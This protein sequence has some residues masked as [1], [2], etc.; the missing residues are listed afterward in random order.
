MFDVPPEERHKLEWRIDAAWETKPWNVGLIVGPSGAGKSTIARAAFGEPATCEWTDAS[1]IDD[2]DAA[3]S[4]NDVAQ[5]CSAVGFNTIPAWLRPYHVLSTGEQFRVT[6]ARLLLDTPA[7]KPIV[8]DEFT[9]V[10][11]RQV[12]KIG[13]NAI[14]KWIRKNNRQFV[15]VTCHYD[16][17][18][19]LQPD[20][21]IDVAQRTFAWRSVQPRPRLDVEIRTVPYSTWQL[22][23]PFHY[24]TAHLH[25]AARCYAAFVDDQPVA[26]AGLLHR[27]HPKTKNIMGVSRVVTLPDWQGLGLAFVLLDGL[28]AS[29][30]H[31]NKRLRT[32]PAHPPLIHAF[33]RSRRWSLKQR[34]GYGAGYTASA[35]KNT[36][37]RQQKAGNAKGI[38]H[39]PNAQLVDNWRHGSRPCAVFEYCGPAYED[40]T[41]A[42]QL[43][44][45]AHG[46]SMIPT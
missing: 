14:Q 10:V 27:P 44:A 39:G 28:G 41:A 33:D 19:W 6:L 26:F 11:D 29:Y 3:H 43:L 38:V 45:E 18:E 13:A 22:F 24:L 40:R 21:V 32:Y 12:A 9:S 5:A 25:R 16:V 31:A 34:P 30:R 17:L 8:V 20:W 35:V 37:L 1:V 2:F 23:A 36:T 7:D 46:R 4:V 42:L 15:A